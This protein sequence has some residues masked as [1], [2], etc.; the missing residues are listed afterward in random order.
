MQRDISNRNT[1]G[2]T[3]N[4]TND[5]RRST[6]IDRT[7]SNYDDAKEKVQKI[8]DLI[9]M[10]KYDAD[11]VIYIP[12]LA[13]LAMQGMLDDIDTREKVASPSYKDKEELDFQILLTDNYYV[14]PSSIHICFPIKLKK[15][16]NNSSNVDGDLITVNNFFAHWV[17]EVSIT[18]YGSDKELPPTFTSWE[19]YQYSDAMLKPLP[20]D[21]LKTLQKH[22]LYSKEKVYYAST[23]YD[24]RNFN[25][26]VLTGATALTN[27]KKAAQA[28]DIN[29]DKRIELFSAHLQDEFIYRVPLRY[30][31]DIGK[32]NFPTK[33]DYR[34]K[35]FVE[36]NTNKLF[37]SRKKLAST[38]KTP[39][40]PDVEILF[41][42]APFVQY[43]QILLDKNFRQH[44]ET[45]MV[46]K[47]IIRMGAQ[48]TPI[49]KNYEIKQG[50]DSLNVEFLGA[51]RQFDRIEISIVNDKCDKHT[52][53]YDSYNRVLAAQ[54][55][56]SLRLS[57]FTEIYSLT[58]E[59]KYS[60][61]NLTQKHL[62]YKQFVAWNLSHR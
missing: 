40:D 28:K 23:G 34:I 5:I 20:K 48:K 8:R 17:K 62:L 29:I 41:T 56:K 52:S 30:F 58:N 38:V 22:L 10:G 59:K 57:N 3:L 44:L 45:I 37:E 31:S 33:I 27:A 25:G 54:N 15:K 47:K 42:R 32:I 35:L 18:K 1:L 51:N 39:P 12:G 60:I 43:E 49:Q 13:D 55:V 6:A 53:T 7:T 21:S 11:L 9:S 16:S 36:T 19:V 50:S 61:N 26:T 4:P 14:N 46:S 24:R 2:D